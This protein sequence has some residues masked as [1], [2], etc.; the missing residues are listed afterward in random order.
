MAN[1]TTVTEFILLGLTQNPRVQMILFLIFFTIY[2][3]TWLGNLTII[4]TVTF[5]PQFH[6][7]MYFF[8]ANLAV[9]DISDSTVTSIKVLWDLIT[10]TH[11]ISYNWCIAQVFFFHFTGGTVSFFLVV[12][13]VDRY[14]AIYKPLQYLLIMHQGVCVGLVTGAWLGGFAHSIVQVA[15]ILQ[16]PFCGPNVLDHFF[17]DISQIVK[18]SCTDTYMTEILMVTNSGLLLVVIFFA[19]L[20]SYTVIL[21][22]IKTHVTEGRHKALS[23]CAAQIMVIS[24]HFGPSMFTYNQLFKVFPGEKFVAVMYSLMTPVLNPIIYT[25][26]NAEMKN[27]IRKLKRKIWSS[28]RIHYPSCCSDFSSEFLKCRRCNL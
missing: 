10:H 24:I 20:V 19:L 15:L 18:L 4:T 6:T 17:C 28:R 11:T 8:L 25:L 5:M 16:L 13:A 3:T 2:I 26:R 23:T 7:P 21:I 1:N 27:A 9:M 14:I 22:K 12:M